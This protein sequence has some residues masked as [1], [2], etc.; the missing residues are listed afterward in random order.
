MSDN[1]DIPQILN[2]FRQAFM[3]NYSLLITTRSGETAH[4][5]PSYLELGSNQVPEIAFYPVNNYTTAYKLGTN[6]IISAKA[7][8]AYIVPDE[9]QNNKAYWDSKF[10]AYQG[11]ESQQVPLQKGS[12]SAFAS[13]YAPPAQTPQFQHTPIQGNVEKKKMGKYSWAIPLISVGAALVIGSVIVLPAIFHTSEKDTAGSDYPGSSI[14]ASPPEDESDSDYSGDFDYSKYITGKN[15]SLLIK[16]TPKLTDYDH[17]KLREPLYKSDEKNKPGVTKEDTLPEGWDISSYDNSGSFPLPANMH[18]YSTDKTFFSNNTC[19]VTIA[20]GILS[21]EKIKSLGNSDSEATKKLMKELVPDAKLNDETAKIL[22]KGTLTQYVE[23]YE[24]SYK[25]LSGK[26]V[27]Y[28]L[29]VFT[30]NGTVLITANDCGWKFKDYAD[31]GFII[32]ALTFPDT[33]NE[34]EIQPEK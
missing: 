19:S 21:K 26:T 30:G 5:I 11:S 3:S 10:F 15:E 12:E 24:F 20:Q 22:I 14:S 34:E 9:I 1:M 25:N 2:E 33:P 7:D 8:P 13:S 16:D 28:D 29:R 4:V 31:N 32:Q 18:G 27:N 17:V 23:A 6:E